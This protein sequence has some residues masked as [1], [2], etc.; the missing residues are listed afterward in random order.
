LVRALKEEHDKAVRINVMKILSVLS[1]AV[2]G[3]GVWYMGK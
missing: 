3:F 1:V 2:A